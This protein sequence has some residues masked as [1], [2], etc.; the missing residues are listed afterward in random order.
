MI[1]KFD[2]TNGAIAASNRENSTIL[3]CISPDSAEKELLIK[4]YNVDEHTLSSALDPDE[5]SRLEFELDHVAIIF[6][7]PTNRSAEDELLFKV[8]SIGIFKF[9]DSLIVVSS[10]DFPFFEGRQF[11]RVSSLNEVLIKLLGRT[12]YHYFEHLRIINMISGEI[13]QKVN[14][15][16]ENKYLIHMFTLGKSLV[17]YLN[18]INANSMVIEKL[19][20]NAGKL[21]ITKEEL[22]ALDDLVI[23]NTQCYKQAEIY[24]NVLS[25]LMDARAG[26]VN[27]N[28][29]VLI[30]RLTII[31]IV[32]MP[33]NLIAGIGGMSEYSMMTRHISWKVA[34]GCFSFSMVLLG[35]LV[36][37]IIS[38]IGREKT[39]LK[40]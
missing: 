21:G 10:D 22:E 11:L 7:R 23:D 13:E 39:K 9:K 25:S 27:N 12:I 16:M 20:Y 40:K 17:Y 31:N 6:K 35:L 18:S 37:V 4:N 8:C 26:V 15:S 5:I 30:K 28:L 19:K 29:N 2:L 24:S 36:Y 38:R 3:V 34:Y 1:K 32:F 14:Q 33:L